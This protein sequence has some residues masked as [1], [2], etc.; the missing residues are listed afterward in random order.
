MFLFI[1]I[2]AMGFSLVGQTLQ[3]QTDLPQDSLFMLWA[4]GASLFVHAVT[5]ISVSYFDQTIIFIYLTLAAISS[6]SVIINPINVE[7]NLEQR[8]SSNS[9]SWFPTSGVY[10]APWCPFTIPQEYF[11]FKDQMSDPLIG[12]FAW[13]SGSW[14]SHIIVLLTQ[15]YRWKLIAKIH[16]RQRKLSSWITPL[17]SQRGPW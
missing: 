6:S 14:W 2:L 15:N 5:F 10:W 12:G 1:A 3:R 9:T 11:N 17:E 8:G 13:K 16:R 7:E 4:L